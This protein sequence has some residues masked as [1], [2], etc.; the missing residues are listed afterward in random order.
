VRKLPG[1]HR[2]HLDPITLAR[3]QVF[4]F[5]DPEILN[6]PAMDNVHEITLSYTF[7]KTGED[8]EDEVQPAAV[9]APPSTAPGPLQPARA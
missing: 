7:F 2:A 3:G 6:D 1:C 8:D 4:F 5:I 9:E